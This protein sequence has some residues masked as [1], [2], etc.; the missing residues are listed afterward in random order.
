MLISEK[1]L[2]GTRVQKDPQRERK[3]FLAMS[4]DFT[5]HIEEAVKTE[6]CISYKRRRIPSVSLSFLGD[7]RRGLLLSSCIT[8]SQRLRKRTWSSLFRS[9]TSTRKARLQT[10][11]WCGRS[12]VGSSTWHPPS[13]MR[14][15]PNNMIWRR[16]R[17]VQDFDA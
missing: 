4:E 12:G 14:H 16:V 7:G 9:S 8:C 2:H 13:R 10:C 6:K 11:Q 15:P 17:D 5:E 1:E 3:K